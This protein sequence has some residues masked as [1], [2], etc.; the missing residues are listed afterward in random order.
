MHSPKRRKKSRPLPHPGTAH[1]EAQSIEAI[2]G[3][4]SEWREKTQKLKP[5][6]RLRNA[7][8]ALDSGVAMLLDLINTRALFNEFR[9]E[10]RL[11]ATDDQACDCLALKTQT[12]INELCARPDH[13]SHRVIL[14]I[15]HGALRLAMTVQTI[16]EMSPDLLAPVACE[17]LYFPGLLTKEGR[18][19]SKIKEMAKAIKLGTNR[20]SM[21]R[22]KYSFRAQSPATRLVVAFVEKVI[23]VR[24]AI[25]RQIEHHRSL[26]AYANHLR[27]HDRTEGRRIKKL[28]NLSLSEYL[29]AHGFGQEEQTWLQLPALDTKGF[30]KWW[31]LALKPHLEKPSTLDAIRRTRFGQEL[32][33]AGGVKDYE[34]RD[35]LKHRCKSALRSLA[36]SLAT[37]G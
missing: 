29:Q 19:T 7:E 2:Q 1:E 8:A 28:S 27:S 16:A 6:E 36:D 12:L 14:A 25:E 20:R 35:E 33:K 3:Y 10:G 9:I 37:L 21:P 32:E 34:I 22:R 31:T 24:A 4:W 17:S 23:N 15:W 18:P 26:R 13:T 30:E 11:V 5:K